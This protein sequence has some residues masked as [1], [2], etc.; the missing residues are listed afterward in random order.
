MKQ[1]QLVYDIASGI[2]DKLLNDYEP[3]YTRFLD[4]KR[5]ENNN[6]HKFKDLFLEGHN[7]NKWFDIQDDKESDDV[8]H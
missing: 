2:Q 7:Y 5:M 6:K 1:K 4:E 3:E 8:K